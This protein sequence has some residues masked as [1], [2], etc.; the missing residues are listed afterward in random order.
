MASDS[1]FIRR[2][3]ALRAPLVAALRA[4]LEAEGYGD[5]A[6]LPVCEESWDR[7]MAKVMNEQAGSDNQAAE[8]NGTP[9]PNDSQ[10]WFSCMSEPGSLLYHPSL[11]IPL[12]L[13]QLDAA[14]AASRSINTGALRSK[15]NLRER[16]TQV[17][18]DT[19]LDGSPLLSQDVKMLWPS[20][21]HHSHTAT[22]D[23]V[24]STI[25][26]TASR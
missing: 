12:D 4:R 18:P 23:R 19:F 16:D 7:Q 17:D 13:A 2:A 8:A 6:K 22:V 25:A 1:A 15:N 26:T 10:A 3:R 9:D 14:I 24:P 20:P 5:A 11:E 21:L